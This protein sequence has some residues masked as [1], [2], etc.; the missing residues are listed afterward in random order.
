M[1]I[2]VQFPFSANTGE[3]EAIVRLVRAVE[4]LGYDS[5]WTGDHLV[6]PGRI[7]D[8]SSYPYHWRFD[9]DLD[10]Y[11]PNKLFLDAV[12][13]CGFIAGATTRLE[14]GVGVFVVPMRNPVQLAKELASIDVLSGGRLIAGV[15]AG[16]MREEF[17]ALG[18][19]YERRGARME[20]SVELM[21]RLWSGES[22]SFDG[23]YFTIEDI[24]SLPTPVR[25]GGIPIWVGGHSKLA[26]ER[27]ARFGSGWHAI[28]LAPDEFE[29]HNRR[30]DALLTD[31]GREPSDVVRS[32]ATRFR[33]SGDGLDETRRLVEQY[34]A[35]G[36]EHLV[37]YQTAS[38]SVDENTDRYHRFMEEVVGVVG[39]R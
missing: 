21:Q 35:A 25:P 31:R 6:I 8:M 4:E 37:V 15:G 34:A 32:C 20:E 17:D 30:I 38:R 29:E 16:W 5:I 18:M 27:A 28:E 36:C 24:Y 26:L 12:S 1:K 23:R 9:S 33:L 2:G 7:A 13:T 22:V 19:A 14:I 39:V 11:F 10:H 3:H